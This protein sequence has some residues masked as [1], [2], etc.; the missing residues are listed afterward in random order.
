VPPPPDGLSLWH[1]RFGDYWAPTDDTSHLFVLAE[2]E[3]E[4]YD[5][6]PVPVAR[7]DVVLDAGAHVG[8]FARH[9][10]AAGAG[11]VIAI[12]PGTKQVECLRRNFAE[13]IAAGRLTI[14]P[15]GVWSSTTELLFQD[16]GSATASLAAA[17]ARAATVRIPVTTID[18]LV[19]ELGLARVDFIKM[20]IEGAEQP[21]LAGAAATLK[22]C[23]P[24]L[25]LAGYH[26][27]SD[28]HE[29]PRLVAA[30]DGTYRRV[31]G[32]GCRLDVGQVRP[33]TLFLH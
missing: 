12:E 14:V 15:K 33:L 23:H 17:G 3:L 9:A 20:D 11:R 2:M 32:G 18:A 7:G 8:L 31:A 30:A 13:A 21:A 1:T 25:A 10:L 6:A 26:L 16:D 28:P 4:L 19:A 24:K 29:I 22:R 5:A 27:P